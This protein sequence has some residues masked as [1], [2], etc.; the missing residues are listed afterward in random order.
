MKPQLELIEREIDSSIHTFYYEND[1]FSSPWHYH[2]EY[3]LT[4]ILKG[5]GIRYTGNSIENF[6]PG[7]LVLVGPSLPHYWK[8]DAAYTGGVISICIQWNHEVL[9]KFIEDSIEFYQIQALLQHAKF[10][11]RIHPLFK[12]NVEDKF[13]KI[14]D[15]EPGKK[16]VAFIDLLLELAQAPKIKTLS[17]VVKG[18]SVD[19]QSDN[20][21]QKILNYISTNY[22][23]KISIKEMAELTFMTE[24]SFCKFFKRRFNK[25][26]TNYLNEFRIRKTCQLLRDTNQKLIDV[27]LNCG[28]ENMS[29]FHRQFKKYLKITPGE[30]RMLYK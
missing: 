27:A 26:F 1:C 30:Y 7:D 4:L 3:E 19:K 24:I 13:K 21:I 18:L 29:F 23:K 10:G 20:R 14:V 6:Y 12:D 16:M 17:G 2:E 15:L 28:Y 25:S 8:N 9:N 22:T 5:S 11:V